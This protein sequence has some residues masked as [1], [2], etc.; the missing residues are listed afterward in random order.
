MIHQF[1]DKKRI[2]KRKKI[3]RNIIGFGIFIILSTIGALTY[4]GK[5]FN[6]I[7]LPIWRAQNVV[8]EKASDLGY[9]VKTKESV[10]KENESLVQENMNLLNSMVDYQIVKN[11]NDQLKELLGRIPVK[12]SFVVANI[13]TKPNHSFYDSI[14][15]D[16]GTNN[17]IELGNKVYVDSK[18]PVGEI[19]KIY[20]D[21]SLVTLYSNPNQITEGVI[22]G[23]N[24]TVELM[25]RGAGN[26]EMTIPLDLSSEKGTMVTLPG[27]S[28]EIVA[29]IDGIV[30][31]VNEPVKKVILHSPVNI[32]S[33]KWV[34]VKKY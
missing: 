32:Q 14:I 7:G 21:T 23:S 10:Y 28:G 4:S 17:G 15:I 16:V 12:S 24:A 18:I 1:H 25:G 20:S 31:S 2:N 27:L 33:V 34:E 13:L 30:S 11:E 29:V 9:L 22:D 8:T 6:N 3:I 19:S 26:F 5:I